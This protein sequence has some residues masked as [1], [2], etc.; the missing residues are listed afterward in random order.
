M[1]I[2]VWT[3]VLEIATVSSKAAVLHQCSEQTAGLILLAN[4]VNDR[5]IGY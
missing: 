1:V 2:R 3:V 5:V 4:G